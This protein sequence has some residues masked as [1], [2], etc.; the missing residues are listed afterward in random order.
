MN[1]ACGE[2]VTL[3]DLDV[4]LA[5]GQ[6]DFLLSVGTPS[7]RHLRTMKGVG[8]VLDSAAWPINNPHR[9]PF[10]AWWQELRR[11]REGPGDFGNLA[12][13]IAYDTINN[14]QQTARD[15]AATCGRIFERAP[16]QPIV[17]VL[18][19]GQSPETLAWDVEVGWEG[20][21]PDLVDSDGTFE[22]P[23]IA[24]GGLVPQR[25]SKEARVWVERVADVLADLIDDGWEEDA[26]G[27]HIL[28]STLQTYIQ[29]LAATGI[30]VRCDTSTPAQQARV[31]DMALKWGYTDRYGLPL[32]LLRRSRFA[33]LAF[34]LCRE[35][36]RLGLP[37]QSPDH[38]WLEELPGLTPIVLHH[39]HDLFDMPHTSAVTRPRP[40]PRTLFV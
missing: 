9:P 39:Q 6:R 21:R 33:R 25:G 1:I 35:R 20:M 34:W 32:P 22:R 30:T 37:W 7:A 24:L 27:V 18:G 2:A 3:R 5:C 26:L 40:S 16:D 15:Y 17:P 36:D 23:L 28:G 8:V 12:Y 14:P 13:A 29:P 11:W 38:A 31:G 4:A 19:F 10:E